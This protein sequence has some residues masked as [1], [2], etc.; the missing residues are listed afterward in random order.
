MDQVGE[1]TANESTGSASGNI[2]AGTMHPSER[3]DEQHTDTP[4]NEVRDQK[5][6]WKEWW[7][8][9]VREKPDRHI[10]LAL[11][12]II[13]FFALVQLI[14]S[15]S[16]NASTSR[17]TQQLITAAGISAYAA[18]QNLGASRNFAASAQGINQGISEAVDRLGRQAAIAEGTRQSAEEA[19][20]NALRATT[21]NFRTEQRPWMVFTVTPA[22]PLTWHD[23][24]KFGLDVP[25]S[26]QLQNY[27]KTPATNVVVGQPVT[28]IR[29][30]S[31]FLRHDLAEHACDVAKATKSPPGFVIYP[32]HPTNPVQ[33]IGMIRG[34]EIH[35]EAS[36]SGMIDA[37]I[38]VCM[39][40]RPTYAVESPYRYGVVFVVGDKRDPGSP[41]LTRNKDVPQASVVLQPDV[42]SIPIID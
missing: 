9:L 39:T 18:Q 4:T 25:F 19:S 24:E 22:G 16:N 20:A 41:I 31:N 29:N 10:E 14:T 2:S 8:L 28:L 3:V 27:G 35:Q 7:R 1:S 5:R 13:G 34:S 30:K 23:A 15:C 40:Y 42:Y 38:G 26:V 21:E 6:T 37:L 17:Q 36:Q 33:L 12:L 11:T 32:D